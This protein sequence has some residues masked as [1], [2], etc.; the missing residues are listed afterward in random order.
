MLLRCAYAELAAAVNGSRSPPPVE[1]C[2]RG[3]RPAPCDLPAAL[4]AC[5][6]AAAQWFPAYQPESI[7][8]QQ[9]DT[10]VECLPSCCSSM[11]SC[12]PAIACVLKG[13][14]YIHGHEKVPHAS[15]MHS[16]NELCHPAVCASAGS[17]LSWLSPIYIKL[18][19]GTAI[20][21]SQHRAP[22]VGATKLT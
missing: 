9:K 4:A 17:E 10:Q 20:K 8:L 12:V 3:S 1:G 14:V 11:V 6:S 16:G 15:K 5:P 19:L 7:I 18:I 21:S 22:S 13:P 2:R